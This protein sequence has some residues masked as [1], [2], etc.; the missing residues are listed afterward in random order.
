MSVLIFDA[1]YALTIE[2]RFNFSEG[3]VAHELLY[4][5]DTL[6]LESNPRVLEA[7]VHCIE[8][9][10]AEYGLSFNTGKLEALNVRSEASIRTRDGSVI[11][12][13]PSI[14]YLGSLI[15][16]DGRIRSELGARIGGAHGDFA[17]LQRVWRLT[18]MSLSKKVCIFEACIGSKLQYALHTCVLNKAERR[19][20]DGFQCQSLRNNLGIL[21]SFY[22][23]VSNAR[24]LEKASCTPW[25]VTITTRQSKYLEKLQGKPVDDPCRQCILDSDGRVK[26]FTGMRRVGRPRV[27]WADQ[28]LR[29]DLFS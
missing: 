29:A 25:S 12:T 6:L 8:D 16:N 22:S 23:R 28:A 11:R 19:R 2:Q 13:K 21:A 17:L 4:A 15:S 3:V 1:K 9:A 7:Y 24:L 18:S 20:I 10:A 5:D 26:H 27:T 14:K